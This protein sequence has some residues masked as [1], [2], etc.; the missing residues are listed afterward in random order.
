MIKRS[1]YRR[2]VGDIVKI[3]LGDGTN[4]FGR[5]LA[6]P[7]M[8]FYGIRSATVPPLEEIVNAPLLFRVW[9]M[10]SAISS[11]HWESLGNLPLH[12][13]LQEDQTFFK[14][15]PM[16]KEYSLYRN[17]DETPAE[18]AECLGLEKAAVWSGEHVEDRLRD[19]FAGV[20]NK[21]LTSM[22]A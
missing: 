20:P 12:E 17:G 3:D 10:N 2:K 14:V 6:E 11:G 7:L 13:N 5:V 4:A 1:R 18:R 9:V 22:T 19:H 21:W 16:T 8:G 15:D